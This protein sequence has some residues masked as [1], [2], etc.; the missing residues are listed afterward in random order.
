MTF[1]LYVLQRFFHL[2]LVLNQ[3][4][5][6][7]QQYICIRFGLSGGW[8]RQQLV[9][10]LVRIVRVGKR[11]GFEIGISRNRFGRGGFFARSRRVHHIARLLKVQCL[12]FGYVVLFA[13]LELGWFS[14][15]ISQTEH[16]HILISTRFDS[17]T[18]RVL[19]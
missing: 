4:S 2:V 15:T 10:I 12:Q 13:S 3:L 6:T 19:S 7:I 5:M 14:G 8:L 9:L 1:A 18:Q 16:Y 11:F 17:N